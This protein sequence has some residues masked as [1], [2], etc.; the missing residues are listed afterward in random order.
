MA[1]PSQQ[2]TNFTQKEITQINYTIHTYS[3]MENECTIP[4]P[5]KRN[6][7]MVM[8]TARCLDN[9]LSYNA[10]I[11]IDFANNYRIRLRK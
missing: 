11:W 9:G 10:I 5:T 4:T 1:Y 2:P 6:K 7:T 8:M 3:N